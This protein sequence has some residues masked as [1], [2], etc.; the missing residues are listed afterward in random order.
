MTLSFLQAFLDWISQ[1][2]VWSGLIIFAIACSESLVLVGLLVPGAVLMFAL[3]TLI[4]TG[5]LDFWPTVSWAVLGAIAGDGISYW[6]GYY[7][8]DRLLKLWPL[9]QHPQ[10]FTK[11]VHYFQRHGGKSV[12]FG[13][14]FGPIR[15]I[16]PAVAGMYGMPLSRFF[17]VNILSAITWAPLYLLPG[18]AFGLSLTVAGEVAGRLVA[19][20]LILLVSIIFMLWLSRRIYNSL[21]PRVD[22]MLFYLANWSRHHPVAGHIPDALI[23]PDH[24]EIRVL[25]LLALLLFLTS[26]VFIAVT[27]LSSET[28]VLIQVDKLLLVNLPELH[29]P[30]FN[31]LMLSIS[32]WADTKSILLITVLSAIWLIWQRNLLALWHLLA[33]LLLT[34]LISNGLPLIFPAMEVRL[35]SGPIMMMTAVFGFIAVVLAREISLAYHLLVYLLA[36]SLIFLTGFAQVYLQLAT[37]SEALGGMTL[38]GIWLAIL[39]IAYRRHVHQAYVKLPALIT[40]SVGL[41]LCLIVIAPVFSEKVMTRQHAP[42]VTMTLTDWQQADWRKQAT[43]RDDIRYQHKYPL[44]L[45]WVGNL[46]T[47]EQQ[48]QRLGWQTPTSAQSLQFLQWLNPKPDV[49]ALPLLPQVHDGHYDVLRMIRFAGP[50]PQFIRLWKTNVSI[51]QTG[52]DLP[53]WVGSIGELYQ[54]QVMGLTLFRT[55]TDS[56]SATMKLQR[57]LTLTSLPLTIE[58]KPVDINGQIIQLLL[59]NNR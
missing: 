50:T 22:K 2:S 38:G 6:L 33:A 28:G 29:N 41:G 34:W 51:V 5:H 56:A 27:Q 42:A 10:L 43:V 49:H 15:P 36:T 13:R 58:A 21:L 18:M 52:K 16:V 7:Y 45:Q 3:G 19:A 1:H 4:S 47:I 12:L 44:N 54:Q 32:S 17:L 57:A 35:P 11:G 53:L 59:V 31:Q 20:I 25:S 39:G 24:P 14:F 23:R 8:Q 40:L 30:W 37:F 9:S 26:S 48:L 46:Q 55:S